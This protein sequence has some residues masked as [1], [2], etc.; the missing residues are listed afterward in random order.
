MTDPL[1]ISLIAHTVF[2]DRRAWLEAA[3]EQTPSLAIEQGLADHALVDARSDERASRRRSVEVAHEGLGVVGKC[4]V[5]DIDDGGLEI[6]EFKSAPIRRRAEVTPAQVTQL[7]L[8]RLCLESAGHTVRAQRVHFTTTRQTV[9]VDLTESDLAEAVDLVARTR[10]IVE[11]DTAPPALVAD[12]RCQSCSHA[13]ICMPDE[14]RSQPIKRRIV[15]PDPHGE[16][17]HVTLPGGRVSVKKGRLLIS[18]M[19]V[20]VRSLPLERVQALTLHGNVDVS[21]AAIREL[22]WQGRVVTWCS[23]RGRV[24]GHVV[25]TRGPNGRTRVDQH[26]R[27]AVGDWV[28]AG[29]LISSKIA[30]QATQLRRNS[31]TDVTVAVRRLRQL[32]RDAAEAPTAAD[33]FGF[34]GHA[35]A[36]YFRH[37]RTMLRDGPAQEI[38]ASWPG[39]RARGARDSL[40]VLLNLAYGLLLADVTR[41][42][43]A[44]GLDP[45]AGFVHSSKRNKPALS[46]DLMEQF[47]P[48]I[49]D[50]VV[51]G[52]INNGEITPD[53]ISYVLGDA[54]LR[55]PARRAL[56]TAYERRVATEFT[57]P[58]FGYRVTWRRAME[59]QARMILGVLDGTQDTY[60]G[61]RVR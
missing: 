25:P 35:A 39:R 40:N 51:L 12:P 61:V 9:D 22:L 7:A 13:S 1:P 38:S 16:V 37:F 24:I 56:I 21:S 34:E 32:A 55:D 5:I 46:L 2:C 43:V 15:V 23:F 42:V 30:N 59:I 20:E 57:H 48:V 58:V 26:V 50:S 10:Q 44:A 11:S 8:Q 19:G 54:R 49:A 17:V 29:E 45:H 28:L 33:L 36:L 27:S 52:S 18:Q 3:G 6:V 41:S 31:R 14:R 47:R 4:D 60:V 53:M